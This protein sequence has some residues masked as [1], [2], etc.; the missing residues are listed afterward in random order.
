MRNVNWHCIVVVVAVVVAVA[1]VVVIPVAV[2]TASIYVTCIKQ[3]N[4]ISV[5]IL[6]SR[7][8]ERFLPFRLIY[9]DSRPLALLFHIRRV[10]AFLLVVGIHIFRDFPELFRAKFERSVRLRLVPRNLVLQLV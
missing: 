9:L 6:S 5:F 1:V 2:A 4:F 10:V 3:F 8:E 7:A